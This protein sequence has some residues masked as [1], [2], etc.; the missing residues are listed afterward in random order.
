M[1]IGGKEIIMPRLK[2]QQESGQQ[3]RDIK[4]RMEV[5]VVERERHRTC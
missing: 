1:E 4:V 2:R 5:E 3:K